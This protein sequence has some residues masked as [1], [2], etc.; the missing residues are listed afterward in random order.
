MIPKHWYMY[1][2]SVAVGEESVH[3]PGDTPYVREVVSRI[4]D[5]ADYDLSTIAMSAHCGTH[6]DAPAHFIAGGK[7]IEQY[8]VTEFVRSALV[9]PVEG[10]DAIVSGDLEQ[11]SIEPGDALLCRTDNSLRGLPRSRVFSEQYVY[12][13][14]EA[15]QT[16]VEMGV[17][18]VGIDYISVD[19]FGDDA[20]PAHRTLLGNGVFVLEGIDLSQVPPGRYILC[21]LPLKL[22]QCEAS[23][24]R[25]ILWQ[26]RD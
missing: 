5:G 15:A 7:T 19:R 22:A 12:L 14:Q 16:C 25:A 13:S 18:L 2:I 1:D 9:V 21:C 10:R 8:P 6:I 26:L 11:L 17:G 24:V 4:A 3:Y 20:Y 23:P